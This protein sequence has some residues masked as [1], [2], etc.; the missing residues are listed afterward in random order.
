MQHQINT[1]RS[2]RM[3]AQEAFERFFVPARRQPTETEQIILAQAEVSSIS[4]S[5]PP[6]TLFSW[7]AGST[8]LL[9]HGWGGCAAQLTAFV[10][11]LVNLGYRVLACDLPAHGQ[12]AGKQTNAFEFAAAIQAI[13]AQQG[14]FDAII[15][16]SWG[17]AATI[18]A[19]SE[20]SI[21]GK[22]VCLSAACWLSSAVRMIAKLLRLSSETEVE[23]CQL[24][25][26]QFG[27]DVWQRASANLR[28]THLGIPGLLFHD[29]H[30]RKIAY[31][32][33]EA[34]AQSW[35]SAQ[36]IATSGL[37][38]EHILHDPDVIAQTAAFIQSAMP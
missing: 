34:I 21:A 16:H 33:S 4:S 17:A 26:R 18:M 22:V 9:V 37:G 8:V 11:P 20:A 14:K 36:L 5:L 35:T 3:N 38:H 32:E 7:G 28:A 25:E 19:L 1:A 23:L 13:A 15:A 6:L 30:D 2:H 29:R 10:P 12:T 27:E 31:A 24:F